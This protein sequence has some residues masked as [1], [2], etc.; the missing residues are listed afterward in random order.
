MSLQVYNIN[1]QNLKQFVNF[2]QLP[3]TSIED[4]MNRWFPPYFDCVTG[5]MM[6]K[7]R[8][9]DNEEKNFTFETHLIGV[10]TYKKLLPFLDRNDSMQTIMKNKKYK[11]HVHTRNRCWISKTDP[12]LQVEDEA[13]ILMFLKCNSII[14]DCSFER[15]LVNYVIQN[16][17]STTSFKD[18]LLKLVEKDCKQIE[19][20]KNIHQDAN[21]SYIYG[22]G[23]SNF[24]KL[25]NMT[26][27]YD[28]ETIKN[29][30]LNNIYKL[31]DQQNKLVLVKAM[32]KQFQTML[33][34]DYEL[35]KFA[36]PEFNL[37]TLFSINNEW[38]FIQWPNKF[39][40]FNDLIQ[41]V[42]DDPYKIQFYSSF[43]KDVTNGI[44]L[45]DAKSN[46]CKNFV[47]NEFVK[48]FV[49]LKTKH[50]VQ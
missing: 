35:L 10:K 13:R 37:H 32:N 46:H 40:K 26:K 6:F 19:Q 45:E 33:R 41:F 30:W 31:D 8:I 43:A 14:L 25:F 11:A 36:N 29:Y 21:E 27:N 44:Y 18:D 4:A 1:E 12:G 22:L 47:N 39:I 2:V 9:N 42:T 28:Y 24:I 16:K 3:S 23:K 15:N 7:I 5:L 38:P 50:S 49:T 34:I 20:L 17:L 48:K